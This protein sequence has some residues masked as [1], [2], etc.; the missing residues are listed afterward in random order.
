MSINL[1]R[2]RKYRKK[3]LTEEVTRAGQK[4][5]K[6]NILWQAIERL[7]QENR[8]PLVMYYFDGERIENVAESLSVSRS[9]A[10]RKIRTAIKQLHKLLIK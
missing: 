7:P 8:L 10:Y 2:Q 3:I 6:Y 5:S 1:V 4:T 9:G